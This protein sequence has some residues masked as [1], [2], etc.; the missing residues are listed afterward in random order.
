ML[1]SYFSFLTA[2]LAWAVTRPPTFRA[3]V[4]PSPESLLRISQVACVVSCN[5]A[6]VPTLLHALPPHAPLPLLTLCI[7]AEFV[8]SGRFLAGQPVP[9]AAGCFSV[10]RSPVTNWTYPPFMCQNSL[11][12]L[13]QMVDFGEKSESSEIRHCSSANLTDV[14]ILT[15][16]FQFH[17]SEYR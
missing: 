13:A 2:D 3:A 8:L 5:A 9:S 11:R 12:E 1:R 4:L 14:S 15:S 17:N 16:P 10:G 7:N 6:K